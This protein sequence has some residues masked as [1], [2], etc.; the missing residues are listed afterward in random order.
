MVQAPACLATGHS[1]QQPVLTHSLLQHMEPGLNPSS[2]GIWVSPFCANHN[3]PPRFLRAALRAARQALEDPGSGIRPT[4]MCM[5]QGREGGSSLESPG[6]QGGQPGSSDTYLTAASPA[7]DGAQNKQQPRQQD[8][9]Q[10]YVQAN[11]STHADLSQAGALQS[12]QGPSGNGG[13]RRVLTVYRSPAG[14]HGFLKSRF[15]TC[16][17][18]YLD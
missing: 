5:Q 6:H 16:Q 12:V 1:L 7:P 17:V 9:A 11:G 8:D 15:N 10:V 3:A 18:A 4:L 14:L 13:Y 2:V